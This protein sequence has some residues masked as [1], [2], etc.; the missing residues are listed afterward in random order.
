MRNGNSHTSPK[1]TT[2]ED[3]SNAALHRHGHGGAP[4]P[5][6]LSPYN[7][8]A[9]TRIGRKEE[10]TNNRSTASTRTTSDR[11]NGSTGEANDSGRSEAGNGSHPLNTTDTNASNTGA[12]PRGPTARSSAEATTPRSNGRG[13]CTH[14]RD[15]A[16]PTAPRGESTLPAADYAVHTPAA[17]GVV[18]KAISTTAATNTAATSAPSTAKPPNAPTGRDS[19]TGILQTTH[20]AHAAPRG[21]R[22]HGAAAVVAGTAAAHRHR[23]PAASPH[24]RRAQQGSR[25]APS[26]GSAVHGKLAF[27]R[28]PTGWSHH[29]M[30]NDVLKNE[31]SGRERGGRED[32]CIPIL[33]IPVSSSL[34]F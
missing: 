23:P 16:S 33:V 21:D 22:A 10:D 31:E 29:A 30:K 20:P 28:A 12:S 15:K 32:G 24:T 4:D 18:T 25:R 2:A 7:D 8:N 9:H 14:S 34:Q 17:N 6:T 19:T 5:T 26:E 3:G 13:E 27:S 11:A 1:A